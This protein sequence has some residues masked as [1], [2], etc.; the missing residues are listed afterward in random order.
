VLA[1]NSVAAFGVGRSDLLHVERFQT[2][3]LPLR[4]SVTV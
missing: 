1:D 4:R 3:P 2:D